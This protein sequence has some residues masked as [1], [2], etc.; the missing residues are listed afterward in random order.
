MPEMV[1]GLALGGLHQ[2]G[3]GIARHAGLRPAAQRCHQ[4][5]L[6]QFLGQRDVAN[7]PRQ[8]GNKPCL[9]QAPDGGDGAIGLPPRLCCGFA[10]GTQSPHDAA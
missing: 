10:H 8:P 9:L 1:D 5:L 4:R 3:A 2:P 6:G 7:H